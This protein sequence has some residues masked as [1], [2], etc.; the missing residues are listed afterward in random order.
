M[1]N[2]A[3]CSKLQGILAK[4]NEGCKPADSL[5]V[6]SSAVSLKSQRTLCGMDARYPIVQGSG[7]I[8]RPRGCFENGFDNMMGI[9]TVAHIDMEVH[10]PPVCKGAHKLLG[11]V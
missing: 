6:H 5:A 3:P 2:E 1:I 8:E 11:K 9:F 4:A 7:L 10:P